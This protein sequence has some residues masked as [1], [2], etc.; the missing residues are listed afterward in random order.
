MRTTNKKFDIENDRKLV[1]LWEIA[2][3]LIKDK[4]DVIAPFNCMDCRI[5][6]SKNLL[7]NKNIKTQVISHGS[8][9]ISS[10]Y[11]LFRNTC[12][13]VSAF[14]DGSKYQFSI[15]SKDIALRA[16]ER[17][18]GEG[19][20]LIMINPGISYLDVIDKVSNLNLKRP[21]VVYQTAGQYST[22]YYSTE[23]GV[24]NPEKI[25]IESLT[26]NRRSR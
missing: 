20:D 22:T 17:D 5:G 3:N 7:K 26:A 11:R 6:Y 21:K 19:A 18:V 23:K 2:L 13:F 14:W 25:L 10:L 9:F 24:F 8:K 15:G 4:A 16:I 12:D 1:R